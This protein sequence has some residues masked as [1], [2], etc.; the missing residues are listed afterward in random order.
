M[1]RALTGLALLAAAALALA[2]AG[3][4][5][6]LPG[7]TSIDAAVTFPHDGD[8]LP[9]GPLVATGTASVGTGQAVANTTLIYIVDVSGSTQSPTGGSA[10]PNQNA[11]DTTPNTVL[12]CELL[13]VHDLNQ[14]AIAT[15]TVAQVGLIGFAGTGTDTPASIT[16]A[17]ALDLSSDTGEQKLVD[18]AQATFPGIAFHPWTAGTDLDWVL[19]SAYL[20]SGVIP[21][22]WP[23]HPSGTDGFTLFTQHA[24]GAQT[25]YYAALQ[26][27]RDL[28]PSV[29]TPQTQVVF[30]SDGVPNLTV[31]GQ[32]LQNI[33]AQLPAT[34]PNTKLTIDTFAIVGSGSTCG[35]ASPTLNGSLNQIAAHFGKTCVPLADPENATTA[36]PDVIASKL[37]D[38]GLTVD[39]TPTPTTVSPALPANGPVTAS[40]AS[41]SL[42]LP[43]GDHTVC[44]TASGSDGGGAGTAGPNCVT[45]TI[46]KAPTVTLDGGDGSSGV[47]GTRD[48]GSSFPVSATAGGGTFTSSTWS[49]DAPGHCTFADPSA[50]STTV[51]CDDDGTYALTITLHDGVNPDATA[52]EHLQVVNVAPDATL[53]VTPDT[54]PLSAATVHA[55]I[56]FTDPGADTWL[57]TVDWG[58]GSSSSVA[59]TGHACDLVHTYT[60]AGPNLVVATVADDDTGADS[61]SG[62]VTVV[63]PPDITGLPTDGTGG[64]A[65]RVDEGSPFAIGGSAGGG[66]VA[67]TATAGTGHCTFA[68]QAIPTSATCDDDGVYTLTVTATDS[69][70]QATTASFHLQVDNVPPTLV[71]SGPAS[72]ASPRSVTFNGIVTDP[73]ANDT[74]TCTIAW[75]DGSPA[76]T[77]PVAGGFCSAAHTYADALAAATITATAADDDGG[78]SPTRTIALTFNR[79]PVCTDVRALGVANLWPPNHKLVLITLTGATDPDGNPLTYRIDGV[80]QDE[81]ITG[82]G[83]GNTAFDAQRASGGSVYLRSE[84]AGTGDG[85]VYTIAYTVTDNG[86]LSC[87]GTIDV[88]VP[89]DAAHPAVKSAASYDSFG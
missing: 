24:V 88:A 20:A 7:G 46:K 34:W 83:S 31:S 30:L 58:D 54:V 49:S 77:V 53:H 35:T 78:V 82:G 2:V 13:A 71:V 64:T 44:A 17:A 21:P 73:G 69:F 33:L 65:G 6:V 60:S 38:A 27:L 18:P 5:A 85:R 15:G 56:T 84:R 55:Q 63:A 76:E 72:G 32:P 1:K 81:K 37:T 3:G 59:S 87:S 80:T 67:W 43:T 79:P 66:A 41:G 62:V 10:C 51:T 11:Y 16:S 36:V 9:A 61:D 52:T 8:V 86:G 22:G 4:A 39:G 19:M 12:D 25:N 45:F 48:E 47:A 75:G 42:N 14:A 70:G 50:L 28:I 23:G 57:C 74:L 26:V 29:T 89:H 68:A 40:L